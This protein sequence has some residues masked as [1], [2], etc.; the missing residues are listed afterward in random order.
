MKSLYTTAALAALAL[1]SPA[2]ADTAAPVAD[3]PATDDVQTVVVTG[4]NVARGNAVVSKARIE[5]ISSAQNIVDAIKLTP[6]VAI[7]GSDAQ[8]LD[9]WTYG[10]NIRGFDVNLRSSKLGQTF[11]DMPGYNASYYLGGAPAQKFLMNEN[12]ARVIVNQGTAAVSSASASALGG[13]LSYYTREPNAEFG[14]EVAVTLGENELRRYAGVLDTG[15]FFNDTTSAYVGVARTTA[16]RWVYGCAD[17]SGVDQWHA[18]A[19]IV[20]RVSDALKLTGYVSYND[21]TDDPIIEATREHLDKGHKDGSHP[22]LK[23][24][25]KHNSSDPNQNWAHGWGAYRKN[26]FGY[27]KVNYKVSDALSVEVA[28]YYHYQDGM[29]YWL[30]PYQQIALDQTVAGVNTRT[31]TGGLAK[32]STRLRSYYGIERNGRQRPVIAGTDYV[33]TDGTVVKSSDCYAAVVNAEPL[34]Y[35]RN[36]NNDK[37]LNNPACA[38]LQT[39]RNS[40]YEHDRYGLTTRANFELGEHKL[41]AGIWFEHLNRDFGRAWRQIKD[42]R[43]GQLDFYGEPQLMDFMQHFKT[44]QIKVYLEDTVTYGD[45]T[46]SGGVQAYSVKIKAIKDAWDAKGQPVAGLLT[47]YDEKSNLLFTLGGVYRLNEGTQLFGTVSQNY[48][49]VG[50]WA[51][52][53]TGTNTNDLKASIATNFDAGFRYKND[54]LAL[55]ATA[56]LISYKNAITF[57]TKDYVTVGGV[58][59]I[60]YTAGTSGSYI[61]TGKGIRSVGLETSALFKATDNLNLY[62][63]VTLNKSEYMSDFLGGSANASNDTKV[64]KGNDVPSAPKTVINL[65]ADYNKGPFSAS[66][67]ANYM[68]KIAGDALNSP[69]QYLPARTVVDLTA[70]YAFT[71]NVSLQLNVNN[72]FD[73]DYIGGALDEFSQKYTRGAPRTVSGTLRARF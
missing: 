52:E 38:P 60:D 6:G 21:S 17:E 51:L 56:Y 73:A 55:S 36:G 5:A 65:A 47:S 35:D 46:L 32:G 71:P 54:R 25:A 40:L 50:D 10:I 30:P 66:F 1:A 14:G 64:R 48:G 7:R 37:W 22:T 4:V 53:K 68:D 9:P 70:R 43:T 62:A 42:V 45:L 8:N 39:F 23:P 19:K 58:P 33:D 3:A 69:S 24:N 2:F 57:L 28:P 29:G 59:G 18:E 61:N 27:L 44:D 31:V 16:C 41:E 12:V 13:T 20:S 15:L 63:A 49:A 67:S 72:L 11:D 34:K 26:I